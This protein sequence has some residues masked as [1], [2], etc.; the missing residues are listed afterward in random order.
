MNESIRNDPISKACELG[1]KVDSG[2]NWVWA[3][4]GT[5]EASAQTFLA[6]LDANSFENRGLYQP[7][8]SEG[9]AIRFR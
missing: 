4:F 9:W 5:D 1:G 3:D 7:H 8:G 2:I 6:W